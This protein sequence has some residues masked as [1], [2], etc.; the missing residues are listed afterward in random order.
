[1]FTHQTVVGVLRAALAA[2]LLAA[3]AL[4]PGYQAWADETC[5]SPFSAVSSKARRTTSTS[6]PW[7]CQ[8][9]G[10]GSDKLV[11][12]D[13]NP[14]SPKLRQGPSQ[15]CPSAGR[16]EAHHMGFSDD[17][18]FLWAGGLDDSK[19]YRLRRRHRPGQA[20]A[21]QDASR[22]CPSKTGCVGPHTFYAL[23]GRVLVGNSCPTP[24]ITAASPAWRC[25]TTTAI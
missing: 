5:N 19:I 16:G 6:G 23:P 7:A 24:T 9:L 25:T 17:R 12:I 15:R 1:M 11:T 2:G 21:G 8:G 13:V 18:R 20:Q 4:A 22:T 3:A 14:G 10:D